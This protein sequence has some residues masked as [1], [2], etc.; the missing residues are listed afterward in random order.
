MFTHTFRHGPHLRPTARKTGTRLDRL[1]AVLIVVTCG[2]LASAAIIPAAFAG[3][4][5]IPDPA[6]YVGDPYIGTA[7][8]APVPATTVR[9][10]STGGMPGWQIALIAAG[11]ALLAAVLA[12]LADRARPAHRD[13]APPAVT[14]E[15]IQGPDVTAD[16]ADVIVGGGVRS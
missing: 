16:D 4:N 12:V 2:L 5:P 15:V 7:P 6:G 3:T 13:T 14:P 10:I 8:V 9:V 1:A 11:A